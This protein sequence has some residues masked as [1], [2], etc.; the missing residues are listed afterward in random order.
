VVFTIEDD[1]TVVLREI[2]PIEYY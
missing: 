1:D 2:E